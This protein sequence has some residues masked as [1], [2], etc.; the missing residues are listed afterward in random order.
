ME[1]VPAE[2]R[3]RAPIMETLS[4]H[5]RIVLGFAGLSAFNAVSF[6]VGFVYLVS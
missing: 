6:Y 3:K 2:R 1:T 5:W 4:H